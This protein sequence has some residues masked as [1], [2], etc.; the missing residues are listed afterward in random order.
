MKEIRRYLSNVRVHVWNLLQ[1]KYE[2]EPMSLA[3]AE[4]IAWDV[5]KYHY[6]EM[7]EAYNAN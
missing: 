1:T 7:K 5:C 6:K 4:T 2:N 3:L